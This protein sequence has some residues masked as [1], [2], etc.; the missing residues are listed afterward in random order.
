MR[1]LFFLAILIFPACNEGC[2]SAPQETTDDAA[3]RV[4]DPHQEGGDCIEMYSACRE[5]AQGE[6]CTSAPFVLR[7]GETG[8]VPTPDGELLTCK[9]P[10]SPSESPR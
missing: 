7:C 5:T 9:C 4:V 6:Q 8:R 2:E 10:E 1:I 3:P